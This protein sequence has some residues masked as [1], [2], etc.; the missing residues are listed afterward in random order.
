MSKV[1]IVQQT[2]T[3]LDRK[4]AIQ[5]TVAAIN[6][7]AINGAKLIVFLRLLF[8]VIQLGSGA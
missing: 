2:P 6:E 3:F 5:K 4:S 8:Q 7:A 1:A